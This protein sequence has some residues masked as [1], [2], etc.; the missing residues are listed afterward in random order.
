MNK[1]ANKGATVKN[2]SSAAHQRELTAAW[3]LRGADFYLKGEYETAFSLF[4]LCARHQNPDGEWIIGHMLMVGE[5]CCQDP[6]SAVKYLRRACRK[7]IAF[8]MYDLAM[9]YYAGEGVRRNIAAFAKYIHAAADKGHAGAAE[10][11]ACAYRDGEGFIQDFEEAVK[12]F[13]IAAENGQVDSM[14]SLYLRYK[15]GEGVDRNMSEAMEWLIK[16]AEAG[17]AICQRVLG[18]AY[19]HG[20]G[21]LDVDK[22]L[23]FEWCMKAAQQG[24]AEASYCVGLSYLNGDGVERND[25]DAIKWLLAAAEKDYTDAQ[26]DLSRA[27]FRK[28]A[29]CESRRWILRGAELGNAECQVG[30]AM[31]YKIG[32]GGFPIDEQESIRW[33]KLAAANGNEVAKRY[34]ERM[35]GD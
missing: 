32:W 34:V 11:L 22:L 5:G 6:T 30:L 2:S 17:H 31:M 18:E 7:G 20:D 10:M 15:L 4:S 1:N 28:G 14:Y 21:G 27:L 9:L 19:Y 29:L 13:T 24:D 33:Y 12:W 26:L 3:F 8:A 35:E 23:A 16:G 25:E